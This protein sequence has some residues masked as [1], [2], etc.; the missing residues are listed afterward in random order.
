MSESFKEVH[1]QNLHDAL[2]RIGQMYLKLKV[3][4]KQSQLIQQ[5][6]GCVVFKSPVT[7][8]NIVITLNSKSSSV[9]SV[10]AFNRLQTRI[11]NN[12][13]SLPSSNVLICN[14]N[15][16]YEFVADDQDLNSFLYAWSRYIRNKINKHVQIQCLACSKTILHANDCYIVS[17]TI[18]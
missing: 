9:L 7:G 3:E 12:D 15:G 5:N 6:N 14:T 8:D 16:R 4:E 13:L 11:W 18:L 17:A 1:L 10:L 2:I